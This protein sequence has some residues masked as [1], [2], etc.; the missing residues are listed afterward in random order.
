MHLGARV[1]MHTPQNTFS[2][3]I[4]ERRRI[5]CRPGHYTGSEGSIA[6]ALFQ[7]SIG[8]RRKLHVVFRC[9]TRHAGYNRVTLLLRHQE[10]HYA[11]PVFPK[12][13]AGPQPIEI[14]DDPRVSVDVS[15]GRD[16]PYRA[17][18]LRPTRYESVAVH[19][20]WVNR[21][22]PSLPRVRHP[23]AEKEREIIQK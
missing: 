4:G 21:F 9:V 1:H 3:S 13:S 10:D 16:V 12:E 2:S 22:P 11:Q 19:A 5:P 17:I 8:H 18:M 14:D 6:K 15:L 20:D 7:L 23:L